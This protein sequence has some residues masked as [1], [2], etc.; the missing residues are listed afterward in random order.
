MLTIIIMIIITEYKKIINVLEH[1]KT[2]VSG[3]GETYFS[4]KHKH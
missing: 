3:L 4:R 1:I 2:F